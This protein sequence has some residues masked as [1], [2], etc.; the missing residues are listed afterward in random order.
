MLPP[1]NFLSKLLIWW[2]AMYLRGQYE[3]GMVYLK[4]EEYS[5]AIPIFSL[6]TDVGGK[7]FEASVA[8]RLNIDVC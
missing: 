4:C 1:D 7:E 8:L 6:L 2:A 5:S 3:K